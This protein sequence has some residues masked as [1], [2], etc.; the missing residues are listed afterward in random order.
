MSLA[1]RKA[2]TRTLMPRCFQRFTTKRRALFGVWSMSLLV[3][4][5]GA[6]R[7]DPPA[8]G[9]NR[10]LWLRADAGVSPGLTGEEVAGWQDPSSGLTFAGVEGARPIFLATAGNCALPVVRFDSGSER[11]T[12]NLGATLGNATIFAAARYTFATSSNNYIYALGNSGSNGSQMSLSRRNGTASYHFNGSSELLGDAIPGQQF[13]VFSQ[14]YRS[15]GA[16]APFHTLYMDGVDLNVAAAPAGYSTAGAMTIGNYTTGSFGFDGDLFE[17]L[18]YDAALSDAD[19]QA[20]EAYLAGR[21]AAT[22]VQS[23]QLVAHWKADTGTDATSDGQPVMQWTSV[24]AGA[25][26][27]SGAKTANSPVLAA[28]S[29]GCSGRALR[30]DGND[31]L[32]GSLGVNLDSGTV[33]VVARYAD[34]I[35]TN[36]YIYAI[37]DNGAAGSQMTLSRFGGTSSYHYNG[38]TQFFG[39]P[40]PGQAWHVFSQVYECS[41]SAPSRHRMFVDGADREVDAASAPY[42]ALGNVVVGNFDSGSFFFRGEVR[43]IR[44]YDRAMTD[45]Q[46]QAI[47]ATLLGSL[48]GS[49]PDAN[50][51]AAVNVDDLIAVILAWGACP[52]ACPPYCAADTNRDCQID[53]DDLIAV[54]LGWGSCP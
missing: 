53:V 12:G 42:I 19:R 24:T 21:L 13:H 3:T 45:A 14:V 54:I 20:V 30:F 18:V 46:R 35:S 22:T 37:G 16:G 6:A 23:P 15:A 43:E 48:P 52:S 25:P 41:E 32:T 9:G 39:L 10:L 38:T 4:L 1:R 31:Q 2:M 5:A 29:L 51:D 47:E 36:S 7:A 34:A 11:L 40:V 8:V 44:V 27:L 17:L 26:I 28:N 50:G 49:L 33:F